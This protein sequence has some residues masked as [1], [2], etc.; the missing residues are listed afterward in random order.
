MNVNICCV[1]VQTLGQHPEAVEKHGKPPSVVPF[2]EV[3]EYKETYA[4]EHVE[5]VRIR[6]VLRLLLLTRFEIDSMLC[7]CVS[8]R[9]SF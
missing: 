1:C 9:T 3:V 7:M 8:A 5:K 2:I 6:S 4:A